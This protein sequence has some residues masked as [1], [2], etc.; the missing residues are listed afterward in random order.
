MATGTVTIEGRADLAAISR[1]IAGMQRQFGELQRDTARVRKEVTGLGVALG[2]ELADRAIDGA[3]A[4]GELVHQTLTARLEVAALAKSTGVSAETFGALQVAADR[5]GFSSDAV[6]GALKSLGTAAYAASTQNAAAAAK[7]EDLEVSIYDTNGALKD[8]ETLFREVIGKLGEV[9]GE[10]TRAGKAQDIFGESAGA[11]T[12]ALGSLSADGLAR[13]EQSAAA[14]TSRLSGDGIAS[15]RKYQAAI[16]QLSTVQAAFADKVS[17]VAAPAISSFTVGLTYV[18]TFAAELFNRAFERIGQRI[19]IFTEAV[20]ALGPV[21]RKVF[22]GDFEGARA[23]LDAGGKKIQEFRESLG[24]SLNPLN[25]FGEVLALAKTK[26]DTVTAALVAQSATTEKNTG[27]IQ[28][29]NQHRRQQVAITDE[30][31]DAQIQFADATAK[32]A[33]LQSEVAAGA[34][35]YAIA[36]QAVG[37]TATDFREAIALSAENLGT[38]R[39]ETE[40]TEEQ[41][42]KLAQQEA[43]ARFAETAGQVS[44]VTNA[45]S[46]L[47]GMFSFAGKSADEMTE[48][49]RRAAMV[50][51]RV[52]QSAAIATAV[53]QT[54]AGVA[55]ALGAAPPP[56]NFINAALVGAAGAVQVAK[57]ASQKPSFALG[58]VMPSTGGNAILHPGE[59]VLSA[60]AV[61][62]MG[63]ATALAAAN[64]RTALGQ[65]AP[66]VVQWRHL[67]RSFDL[68]MR[69]ASRRTGS[70]RDV[71]RDGRRAGQVRGTVRA[72]YGDL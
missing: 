50:A 71:R 1:S 34:F 6:A 56:V 33:P 67:R 54:A 58:G 31:I 21:M 59:G 12:G 36:L 48:R 66:V 63:G 60:G 70:T 13:A 19:F 42:A 65:P 61:D 2:A 20:A 44:M 23:A 35:G 39:E 51:F 29:N 30:M 18:S 14:F 28:R 24:L 4:L 40:L 57:I 15:A 53:I 7:F 62:S 10:A 25:D 5:A 47:A 11:L 69:D 17:D 41:L 16:N 49:Q 43:F 46:D 3:R 37:Q 26:A 22:A 45:V 32:L 68:E 64:S 38:L 9:E 8:N 52:Q 27:S 72:H 55:Q